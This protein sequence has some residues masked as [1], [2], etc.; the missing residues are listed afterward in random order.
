MRA[1]LTQFARFGVV[2]LG[3]LA[4]DFTVFNLLRLTVLS[5]EVLA[6]GPL[7][8]KVVSTSLAIITNWMGNRY[9]TFSRENRSPMVRE[10]I[11]FAIISLGGMGISLLC[12]WFSHYVLGF[13]T[14]L[15]DNIA[16]YG[17]GLALGTAFRFTFYRLWVF[18][19]RAGGVSPA[20][21]GSLPAQSGSNLS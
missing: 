3:G 4:V 17:V 21:R 1:L 5:P 11:E 7:I 19:P 2:G 8:A 14:P 10:G 20:Q 9:W 15:A 13:T 6:E 18:R 12:L 16:N